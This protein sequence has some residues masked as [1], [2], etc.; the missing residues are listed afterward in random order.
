MVSISCG[1]GRELSRL[2]GFPSAT[3]RH[4]APSKELGGLV[5]LVALTLLMFPSSVLAAMQSTS[6][7]AAVDLGVRTGQTVGVLTTEGFYEGKVVSVDAT[8]LVIR[9]RT[10]PITLP[11][12]SVRLIDAEF[13]DSVANGALWGLTAGAALGGLAALQAQESCSSSYT[14]APCGGVEVMLVAGGA[15]LGT[16]IGI[17]GDLARRGRHTVY[18]APSR[19]SVSV[20]PVFAPRRTGFQAQVRW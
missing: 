1:P 2:L 16:A 17:L 6:R 4:D 10:G 5:T 19:L 18:R 7:P 13:N 3:R 14:L 8:G 11:V 20:A 9:A 15:A 12:E